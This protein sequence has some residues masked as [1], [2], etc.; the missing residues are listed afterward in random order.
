MERPIRDLLAGLAFIGFGVAFSVG[1]LSYPIGSPTRMGPGFFPLVLGGLLAV[2]GAVILIRPSAVEEGA[3]PEPLIPPPWGGVGLLVGSL[4]LF[5]LT[6]RGLGLVGA[7]FTTSLLASL[8]SRQ[9]RPLGALALAG[10]LTLVSVVIFVI[11]L[12]L[13]LPLIGPWL[14]R[15]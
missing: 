4:L 5:G 10:T 14:P 12:Q 6:V 9:T 3:E 1:A 15:L 2:L 11:G 13:N 8:A 7:V